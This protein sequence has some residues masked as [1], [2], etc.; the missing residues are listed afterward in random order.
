MIREATADGLALEIGLV[1]P[2]QHAERLVHGPS[3][4]A[5]GHRFGTCESASLPLSHLER[6]CDRIG[7][8]AGPW[9]NPK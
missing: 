3:L 4:V 2:A 5:P 9:G 8:Q 7:G 6:A 1:L